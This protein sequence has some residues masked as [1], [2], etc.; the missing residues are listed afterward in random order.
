MYLSL[1][2]NY[3]WTWW[4]E[5][6]DIQTCSLYECF[7]FFF[8]KADLCLF[9][10]SQWF[11]VIACVCVMFRVPVPVSGSGQ[12]KMRRQ[13]SELF[14]EGA[15]SPPCQ[16]MGAMVAFQCF[17]DFKRLLLT[18]LSSFPLIYGDSQ[19][20]QKLSPADV[21]LFLLQEC[22]WSSLQLCRTTLRELSVLR[23]LFQSLWG[24][25]PQGEC[26]GCERLLN[27]NTVAICVSAST[28]FSPICRIR[29]RTQ[30]T[31]LMCP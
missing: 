18:W 6:L 8:A 1:V 20:K 4:W 23:G 31:S 25:E 5:Y 16:R 15:L 17:D 12:F 9:V 11:A 21:F 30:S 27:K 28:D 7:F 2:C 29:G 10:I 22:R 24:W 13:S 3:N 14:L 26:C 19:S